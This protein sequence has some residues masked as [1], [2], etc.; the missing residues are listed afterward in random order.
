L[1]LGFYTVCREHFFTRLNIQEWNFAGRLVKLSN[2]PLDDGLQSALQKGLNF[3]ISPTKLP[4]EDIVT[5]VEKSVH[6]L[7]V[8]TAEEIREETES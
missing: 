4:I 8:E 7:P 6:S 5:G 2:K 1:V 3:A